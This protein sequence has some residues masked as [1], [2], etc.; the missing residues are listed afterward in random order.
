MCADTK[1][2]YCNYNFDF[3]PYG[4][5]HVNRTECAIFICSVQ[6]PKLQGKEIAE[7]AHDKLAEALRW[8]SDMVAPTG[9]AAGTD[10]ITLADLCFLVRLRK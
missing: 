1:Q 6:F 5:S 9:Y 7:G 3:V 4:L 10:H 2:T 8:A